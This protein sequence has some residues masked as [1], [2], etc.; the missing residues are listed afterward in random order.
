MRSILLYV[1][2]VL[3]WGSTWLA[4]EFQLGVVEPQV[5]LVY[6]F[7]LA[8]VL[9]WAYIFFKK[10]PMNYSSKDHLFFLA[11][12]T[13]VFGF[14]YLILYWAQAYLT[15]AMT[16][17]AFST[18]LVMNILNTRLWFG[19]PIA[20]RI[21]VGAVLGLAGI[22]ALFWQ[23]IKSLDW[24]SEAM[25]G[26]GLALAGT[27]V[28]SFG[29]MVSVRNSKRHIGVMQGNAWG[30]LY[31]TIILSVVVLL[32]GAKF[33]FDYALP[34]IASLLYLSVFGT[35]VAFACYFVL[36]KE[37]GPEKASYSTVM[38]PVVAVALSMMF[39]GFVWQ[40]NTI[41][42]FVLVL[43]GNVVVLT[44]VNKLRGLLIRFGVLPVSVS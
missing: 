10:L 31:G 30:M 41:V 29:N 25:L 39:E 21:Y 27:L 28:A 12:A 24:S 19:K 6:R 11:L 22:V 23:D 37:I 20:G 44:P 8:A 26:L 15:S 18:L 14:N 32:S 33:T 42:G 16:S 40:A 9:M 1:A 17:I 35:V 2:T 36:L 3:I 43:I 4:I 13:C 7:G 38:F 5:S 34:Y